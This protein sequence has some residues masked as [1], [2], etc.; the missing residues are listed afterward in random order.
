MAQADWAS[1][2]CRGQQHITF[3]AKPQALLQSLS[4]GTRA[5]G[6]FFP[7][8]ALRHYG[9]PFRSTRPSRRSPS[10]CNKVIYRIVGV[11]G[12]GGWGTPGGGGVLGA[13]SVV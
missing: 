8:R 13:K 10:Y 6:V 12:E 7:R 2:T 11:S 3:A 4:Q 1:I 5:T 9:C